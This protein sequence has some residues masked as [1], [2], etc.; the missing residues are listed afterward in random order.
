MG[1]VCADARGATSVPGL[2]AAGEVCGGLHGANRMGGN[3]LTETVVLGARAGQAAAEWAGNIPHDGIGK[4]DWTDKVFEPTLGTS[5]GA[6]DWK[7]PRMM[8]ELRHCMWHEGG[9]LR[10]QSGLSH[11]FDVVKTISVQAADL[12]LQ[13]EQRQVQQKLELQIAAQTAG[14]ILQGAIRRQESRGAHFREDYPQQDDEAWCGH[15]LV[16]LRP[17]KGLDW[18][19]HPI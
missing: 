6:D 10:S 11:A 15:L 19:Y 2:F 12:P 9:I 17:G 7:A 4:P 14:L 8:A 5:H 13:G 1:G 3:A 16:R 18:R